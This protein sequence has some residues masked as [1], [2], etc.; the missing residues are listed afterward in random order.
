[1]LLRFACFFLAL[2]LTVTLG[3]AKPA[4]N[5]SPPKAAEAGHEDHA[6]EGP[7]HG[8]LIE[9]AQGEYH[10]E[11]THDDATK[12]ITVYLLGPDAK[13]PVVIAEPE[14]TLNLKTATEPVQAKLAAASQEGEAAGT[15][16]RFTLVDEK[17]LELL[18]AP[19]TSTRLNVTID[20]K[21]YSGT[22]EHQD[23]GHDH[24]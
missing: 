14:I 20:G 8:H 5:A 21:V 17:V 11:L 19:K 1:M 16:S 12:T 4:D 3:C 24:K 6:E 2:S 18:E 23:H 13:A 7:H 15:S 22:L 10:A 9:L